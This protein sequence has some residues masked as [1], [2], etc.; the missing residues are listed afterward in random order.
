M[1]CRPSYGAKKRYIS[2]EGARRITAIIEKSHLPGYGNV[3]YIP[4]DQLFLFKCNKI[5]YFNYYY[6]TMLQIMNQLNLYWK[7]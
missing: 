1:G 6:P 7:R 2:K 4:F 5:K 3:V